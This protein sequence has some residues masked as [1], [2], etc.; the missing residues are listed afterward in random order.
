LGVKLLPEKQQELV[1]ELLNSVNRNNPASIRQGIIDLSA[2]LADT[3][4]TYDNENATHATI[5]DQQGSHGEEM[6]DRLEQEEKLA[7]EDLQGTG[8]K[9]A[10]ILYK[11]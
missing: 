5:Q 6:E 1:S 10:Y 4:R 8:D 2:E 3:I 9:I 7:L 11:I